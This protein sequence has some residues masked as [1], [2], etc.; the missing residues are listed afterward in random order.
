MLWVVLIGFLSLDGFKGHVG[1]VQLVGGSLG[2]M[3]EEEVNLSIKWRVVVYHQPFHVL[4]ILPLFIP[5][6]QVTHRHAS[7]MLSSMELQ[8]INSQ[9]RVV[10]NNSL[11]YL[12]SS[13]RAA[14]QTHRGQSGW[15]RSSAEPHQTEGPAYCGKTPS[16]ERPND[17][18]STHHLQ[19]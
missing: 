12:W 1:R 6:A 19:W 14:G 16:W 10:E 7:H 3:L 11:T 5:M 8:W 13:H 2:V 4:W 9:S 18:H 17:T 15:C